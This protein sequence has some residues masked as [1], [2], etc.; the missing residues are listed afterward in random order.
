MLI[1][2]NTNYFT[3]LYFLGPAWSSKI[4]GYCPFN[5]H[6]FT[7][8]MFFVT[9]LF[10]IAVYTVCSDIKNLSKDMPFRHLQSRDT[11][12]I[13]VYE[14][15]EMSTVENCWP[16]SFSWDYSFEHFLLFFHTPFVP[17]HTHKIYITFCFVYIVK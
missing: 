5:V 16:C 14:P 17:F 3:L 1:A 7:E 15:Q 4:S 2:W 10:S 11:A 8:I 9:Y 12:S 6:F 13:N